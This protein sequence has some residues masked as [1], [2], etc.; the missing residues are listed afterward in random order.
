MGNMESVLVDRQQ[1]ETLL[2]LQSKQFLEELLTK[3][4]IVL[5]FLK[6]KTNTKKK[7]EFFIFL[8]KIIKIVT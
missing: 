3:T 4:P 6:K 7:V 8:K 5:F 1:L 2:Q